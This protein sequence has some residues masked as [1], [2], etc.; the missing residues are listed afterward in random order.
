[1]DVSPLKVPNNQESLR[2][3]EQLTDD[4]GNSIHLYTKDRNNNSYCGRENW[5]ANFDNNNIF[6]PR[7]IP[8]NILPNDKIEYW[9]SPA[10]K[11]I[12]PIP[13]YLKDKK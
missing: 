9:V 7:F 13:D 2:Y 11:I 1:M 8:Y 4:K 10:A 5:I 3:C 12:G 6:V